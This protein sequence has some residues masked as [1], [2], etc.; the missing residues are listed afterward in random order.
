MTK[1]K[2]KDDFSDEDTGSVAKE[3]PTVST[4]LRRK[5]LTVISG[6]QSKES[7]PPE[8]Q[9]TKVM[10]NPNQDIE[11]E[12]EKNTSEEIETNQP[13]SLFSQDQQLL[14]NHMISNSEPPP[15]KKVLVVEKMNLKQFQKS[16]NT[17]KNKNFI[18][19]DVIGMLS[20]YFDE[21]S[22]FESSKGLAMYSGRIGFGNASLSSNIRN[23][24]LGKENASS[25]INLAALEKPIQMLVDDSNLEMI[26][27]FKLVGFHKSGHFVLIPTK[28]SGN[29]K[30]FW[31]CIRGSSELKEKELENLFKA[32]E[33]IEY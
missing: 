28:G 21:F 33:K 5:K 23:I 26:E 14:E 24:I 19:L 16:L 20:E 7:I 31:A 1:P 27:F 6:S 22:L 15:F 30:F 9:S 32:L 12:L 3:M 10:E 25:I 18:L 29:K 2:V 17:P 8:P 4:L 13:I 11:L